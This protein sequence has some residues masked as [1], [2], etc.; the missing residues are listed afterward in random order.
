[1]FETGTY[2]PLSI[3]GAGAEHLCAYARVSVDCTLII[4]VSRWAA[5]LMQSTP[6]APLGPVW[7]DTRILLPEA[8]CA[9]EYCNV[10]TGR[11]LL[12]GTAPDGPRGVNA[13]ELFHS[14]PVAVLM[15]GGL[16]PSV[17]TAAASVL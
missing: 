15:A 14:L 10:F 17:R 5:T 6:A 3:T 13:S 9:G 11:T 12:I 8:V 1:V 4:V 16:I 2:L 7:S